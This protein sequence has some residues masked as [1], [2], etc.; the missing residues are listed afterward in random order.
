MY[1]CILSRESD[2]TISNVCLSIILFP[3]PLLPLKI[4]QSCP[5]P[6]VPVSDLVYFR[7]FKPFG[8]LP[9]FFSVVG[10]MLKVGWPWH[11]KT[12]LSRLKINESR[13]KGMGRSFWLKNIIQASALFIFQTESFSLLSF[14]I[15]LFIKATQ[16]LSKTTMF[17]SWNIAH[18]DSPTV[19]ILGVQSCAPVV[20]LDLQLSPT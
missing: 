1:Q 19:R 15:V 5:S 20:I 4:M 14:P 12:N 8:F 3:N 13:L 2:S 9:Y 18:I 6:I 17:I 11:L 10:L 7:D 16:R